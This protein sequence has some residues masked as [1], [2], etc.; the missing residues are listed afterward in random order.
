ML[1]NTVRLFLTP[2]CVVAVACEG[3][4]EPPD[5]PDLT[6]SLQTALRI[7]PTHV[8]AGDSLVAVLTISNPTQE[9]ITLASNSTCLAEITASRYWGDSFRQ[10]GFDGTGGTDCEAAETFFGVPPEDSLVVVFNLVAWVTARLPS[11]DAVGPPIPGHYRIRLLLH[12][13]LRSEEGRLRILESGH[14]WWWGDCADSVPSAPDS[15]RVVVDSAGPNGVYATGWP[16]VWYRVLNLSQERASVRVCA[17]KGIYALVDQW[18]GTE[19]SLGEG[20]YCFLHGSGT[21]TLEPNGC[22]RSVRFLDVDAMGTYRLWVSAGGWL[23]TE[24]LTIP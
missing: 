24:P 6:D 23:I 21:H 2:M 10:V 1:S 19:W 13:P 8:I 18:T 7:E 22:M 16:R 20:P 9:A 11:F 5:A 12:V 4:I 15:L 14:H 17:P 3:S